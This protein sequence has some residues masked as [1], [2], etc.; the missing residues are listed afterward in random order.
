MVM[1]VGFGNLKILGQFLCPTF[2]DRSQHQSIKSYYT[3]LH[4][5]MSN[6]NMCAAPKKTRCLLAKCD[7]LMS[8][9]KYHFKAW[10][11][12][13]NLQLKSWPN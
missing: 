8:Q 5:L 12:A 10:I 6:Q 7:N 9:P 11:S 1:S 13:V 3:V 2:G 4:E